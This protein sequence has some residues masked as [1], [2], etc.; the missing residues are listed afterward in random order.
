M[1]GQK[2]DYALWAEQTGDKAWGWDAVLERYKSFEDYHSGANEW[3]GQGKEWRVEK[4]R[5]KWEVLEVF[6]RAAAAAG[7]PIVEDF[8]RGNNFGVGYFDVS[9]ISGW[10]LNTSKAFLSDASS[11][12]NL[13]IRTNTLV[14][15]LQIDGSP[16]TKDCVGVVYYENGQLVHAQST[17]ETI[18]C[19]GSIGSV[20]ILERSGI[21]SSEF[22][23]RLKIPPQ[24]CR[25]S[26]VADTYR[27][28]YIL[29]KTYAYVF[30]C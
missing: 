29:P 1:R 12:P 2:E 6:K 8:N 15:S 3:H 25:C 9:Q 22:L 13:T 19:A 7:V 24:V 16:G 21:G 11:R 28:T 4:Q 14:S 26:S 20:Q 30:I 10:R 23:D 17:R 27:Q 18:L 5:L